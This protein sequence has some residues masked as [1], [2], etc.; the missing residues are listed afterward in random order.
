MDEGVCLQGGAEREQPVGFLPA[1]RLPR[2][3]T[4]VGELVLVE[5]GHFVTGGERRLGERRS[6]AT[7]ADDQDE[8][9]AAA[10]AGMAGD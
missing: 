8:H 5:H 1:A 10:L 6:D 4:L 9:G 3:E 2:V 7:G